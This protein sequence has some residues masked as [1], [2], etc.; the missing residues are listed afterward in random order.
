MKLAH[1]L[2]EALPS[3]KLRSFRIGFAV[4]LS[5]S[6]SFLAVSNALGIQD[7]SVPDATRPRPEKFANPAVIEFKGAIDRKLGIYFNNRMATAEK[8]GVD[9]LIIEIDSPG[10]EKLES[11]RMARMLRD[12]QWAYTVAIISNEAMSGGALVSLGCDEILIDPNGKFGD[13]GEIQFDPEEWAWRLIQPKIKSYLSRDAR[14]LA[15]SKGRPAD[16]AEAMV[17]KDVLVYVNNPNANGDQP[18]LAD[19]LEFTAVRSDAAAKPDAPWE[20]VPESGPERFLT[21]SG[22]RAVELGMAQGTEGSR[23]QAA[24]ALGV[25]VNQ[26]RIFRPTTSDSLAYYLNL[27]LFTG[28]LILVGLVAF[29]F[30]LSSPGLGVGGLLSALCAT[31]FFWSRFLGGTS[32]WLEIILFVAGIIFLFT[33][34]F[35]IP[36]FGIP[37]AAGLALIFSSAILASQNFVIPTTSE[38]WNQSL[39][40]A[41]ILLI[42]SCAFLVA[43]VFISKRIGSIPV[44][45]RMVLAP[46][47]IESKLDQKLDSHGKPIQPPH[48]AVS[49]GDWGRT[50]S[51]LRP[52]GRAKF[53]DRSADVISDGAFVEIG[54]QVRV[55]KITG[56]IITV[57]EI[58]SSPAD[59]PQ[60]QSNT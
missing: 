42:S 14:D 35:V 27:P 49:V 12:C 58:E 3:T 46:A 53:G 8:S 38:E 20:L 40:S 47:P 10:G 50:E 7:D 9:L 29:Y 52:S 2:F 60:N 31:M 15:Q 43:A 59:K 21:L 44:F 13:A 32:G 54:A 45:N 18:K 17:D 16:L 5:L 23:E 28:L 22:Q 11:L 6:I 24:A 41:L 51:L 30:E 55:I 39:T 1:R 26:L 25:E 36:G 56:N 33:E 57:T 19:Q 34:V 4:T 37:G 48:P